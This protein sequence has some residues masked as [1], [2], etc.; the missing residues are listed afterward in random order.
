MHGAETLGIDAG[1]GDEADTR[2]QAIPLCKPAPQLVVCHELVVVG[3]ERGRLG[4]LRSQGV[5]ELRD[6][7]GGRRDVRLAEVVGHDVGSHQL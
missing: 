1:R 7:A 5:H 2:H 3:F 4:Q 6:G